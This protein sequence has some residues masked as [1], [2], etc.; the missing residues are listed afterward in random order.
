[1]CVCVLFGTPSDG[2]H[3]AKSYSPGYQML[4]RL[5][6]QWN[7]RSLECQRINKKYEG[8]MQRHRDIW[9][10]YLP[11]KQTKS[12]RRCIS[13][14]EC[15]VVWEEVSRGIFWWM[16][17]LN[18]CSIVKRHHVFHLP[19]QPATFNTLRYTLKNS[20]VSIGFFQRFHVCVLVGVKGGYSRPRRRPHT[21]FLRGY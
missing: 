20:G 14:W 6:A 21:C 9:I 2:S 3:G 12:I 1:M 10:I 8:N 18:A 19:W 15:V 17:V 13:M 11:V 5:A 16:C 4:H 7:M